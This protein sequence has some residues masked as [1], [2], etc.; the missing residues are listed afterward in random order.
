MLCDPSFRLYLMWKVTVP[1]H[2]N[3]PAG[4]AAP[5]PPTPVEVFQIHELSCE[6]N[7]IKGRSRSCYLPAPY[8][9]LPW[10]IVHVMD[11][12]SPLYGWTQEN[13]YDC[14]AEIIALLEGV[15]ESCSRIYQATYSYTPQHMRWNADFVEMVEIDS[16][17]GNFVIRMDKLSKTVSQNAPPTG[18]HGCSSCSVLQHMATNL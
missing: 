14:E 15:D 4:E 8:L 6:I 5:L 16:H 7:Q 17:T 3:P 11:E 12:H 1:R 18:K 9:P 2:A 13:F 10:T